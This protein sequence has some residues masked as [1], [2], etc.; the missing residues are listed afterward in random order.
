MPELSR[1]VK[2]K[3]GALLL[4]LKNRDYGLT[5]DEW[6]LAKVLQGMKLAWYNGPDM[7]PQY[8]EPGGFHAH[9]QL[10][11]VSHHELTG[12]GEA[13]VLRYTDD[14]LRKGRFLLPGESA[15]YDRWPW[16]LLV[17]AAISAFCGTFSSLIIWAIK[18]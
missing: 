6:Q 1:D 3:L 18:G 4:R 16:R 7:R 5:A 15:W 10:A 13:L 12:E 11:A 14:Q 17:P 8:F 9:L 2:R